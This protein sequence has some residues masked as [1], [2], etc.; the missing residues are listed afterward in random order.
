MFDRWVGVKRVTF[1]SGRAAGAT[2]PRSDIFWGLPH[3]SSPL[4]HG[5][6]DSPMWRAEPAASTARTPSRTRRGRLPALACAQ[7]EAYWRGW[8]GPRGGAGCNSERQPARS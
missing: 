7:V 1:V 6:R 4:V 3:A 8:H 2:G 5:A